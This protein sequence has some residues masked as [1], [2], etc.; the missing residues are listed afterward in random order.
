MKFICAMDARNPLQDEISETTGDTEIVSS[1]V[2][3]IRF[4]S[5]ERQVL[6]TE[7]GDVQ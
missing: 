1:V 6:T 4:A 3:R 7:Q 2:N 5:S